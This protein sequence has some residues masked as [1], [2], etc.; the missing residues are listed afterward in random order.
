M[1]L[2]ELKKGEEIHLGETTVRKTTDRKR[3]PGP[4]RGASRR[5][6][7]CS[8]PPNPDGKGATDIRK[9]KD[10]TQQKEAGTTADHLEKKKEKSLAGEITKNHLKEFGRKGENSKKGIS[11]QGRKINAVEN[12]LRERRGK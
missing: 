6:I 10:V 3:K 12:P 5:R 8:P 9:F 1:D 11:G 4:Q 2:Y 7:L